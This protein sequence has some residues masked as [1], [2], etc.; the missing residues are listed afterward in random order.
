MRPL[1][2][3]KFKRG[4]EAVE[5]SEIERWRNRGVISVWHYDGFPRD[6]HGYHL[7]ADA[8]G[9][10]FLKGLVERLRAGRI[11]DGKSFK[12]AAP[13]A[14]QLAVPNCRATCV[15][16]R[17]LELRYRR[18]VPQ[19]H[20]SIEDL[21]GNLMIE[22]GLSKLAEFERGIDDI[23]RGEGDWAIHG[24]SRALWLWG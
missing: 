21:E 4:D 13:T 11:P 6:Y 7:H 19:D 8:A 15:P 20:W 23:S 24:A 18:D 14:T 10:S 12:L 2:R 9:C 16:A 5:D 3:G 1:D 17:R 22:M